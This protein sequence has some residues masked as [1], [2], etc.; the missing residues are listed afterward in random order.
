MRTRAQNDK[1]GW[2]E[3][4]FELRSDSPKGVS[5]GHSIKCVGWFYEKLPVLNR[6]KRYLPLLLN[7]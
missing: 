4:W 5:V 1:F 2:L 7:S 6:V 3:L